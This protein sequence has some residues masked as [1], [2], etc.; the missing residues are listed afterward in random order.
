MAATDTITS[1]ATQLFNRGLIEESHR[2]QQATDPAAARVATERNTLAKDRAALIEQQRVWHQ[3]TQKDMLANIQ[4]KE[5]ALK[6]ERNRLRILQKELLQGC[7]ALDEEVCYREKQKR[8][9][10]SLTLA[11]RQSIS[12][13]EQQSADRLIVEAA[14]EQAEQLKA[15][16][17]A[18]AAAVRHRAQQQAA[19]M[20]VTAETGCGREREQLE[21]AQQVLVAEKGRIAALEA[22]LVQGCRTLGAEVHCT[23]QRERALQQ[24][25]ISLQ[26][27]LKAEQELVCELR[28]QQHKAGPESYA[29]EIRVAAEVHAAEVRS[30]AE[31][32]AAEMRIQAK[33]MKTA[34]ETECRE[35]IE[36][37]RQQLTDERNRLAEATADAEQL[38]QKASEC[39]QLTKQLKQAESRAQQLSEGKFELQLL[40]A[41]QEKT[42]AALQ[43][44]EVPGI[45]IA[46]VWCSVLR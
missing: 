7:Q 12:T 21:R 29:A 11:C 28:L 43:A 32:A 25:N 18:E 4:R 5:E 1:A 38:V 26:P 27:Q 9:L 46:L 37:A 34:A 33:A 3:H 14:R 6:A 22:E 8:N 17:E 13:A 19:M 36:T 30:A 2:Q 45:L 15:A 44:P 41:Q 39:D 24:L 40:C 35:L 16:A 42:I 20:K 23:E 31:V 10:E